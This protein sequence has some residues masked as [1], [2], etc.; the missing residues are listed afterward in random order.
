MQQIKC[1]KCN[2]AFTVDEAGYASILNQVKNNEFEKEIR[3]RLNSINENHK[4]E[5][6]LAEAK[7][8]EQ[9]EK[10]IAELNNRLTEAEGKKE[11]ELAQ[12]NAQKAREITE[13][14]V[15]I[16]ASEKEKQYEIEKALSEKEK[17]ILELDAKIKEVENKKSLE[18]TQ[19]NAQKEKEIAELKNQLTETKG[20]KEIELAQVNAQKEKEIIELQVQIETSNKDKQHEIQKAISEKEKE[21]LELNAKIKEEEN[22]K[23]LELS[24]LNFKLESQSKEIELEKKSIKESYEIQ[25]KLKDDEISQV[26]DFKQKQSTKMLGESLEQHCEIEFNR[27]RPTAF[28]N[29]IFGKDNDIS[30]GTKG[31]YIYRDFEDDIEIISIMFEMKN[32]ADETTTKKKNEDYFKK[33]DKDRKDKNCEYAILVSML[34]QENDLYHGITDVSYYGYEKM[35]VIRPQFFIPVISFLKNAARNTS[36]YK[37]EIEIIRQQNIDI[38][39]FEDDFNKVR[40]TFYK[41]Y[42]NSETSYDKAI[43]EIDKSIK[44]MEET[45]KQLELSKKHLNN[46]NNKLEDVSIKKLTKNNPTMKAKFEELG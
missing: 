3:D 25:L 15:K 29:A 41:H 1:P 18:I 17:Q 6:S 43:A 20:K 31:D 32:E 34:E 27:L 28:P 7:I 35:Y 42:K 46:A 44:A 22:K 8:R 19:M 2:E 39:N 10:E 40:D 24:Q 14:Q 26:K 37:K 33:L 23:A 21:I 36:I 30:L 9:K 45:K 12:I 11:I 38:T 16:E 4:Q 13:L 5:L